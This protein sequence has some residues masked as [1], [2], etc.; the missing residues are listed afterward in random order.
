MAAGASASTETD[1]ISAAGAGKPLIPA[2]LWRHCCDA[3][4]AG[5]GGHAKHNLPFC[6]ALILPL[7]APTTLGESFFQ[8]AP[9]RIFERWRSQS[10]RSPPLVS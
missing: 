2:D 9:P 6:S 8:S 1:C 7:P 3:C 4:L 5:D 10:P